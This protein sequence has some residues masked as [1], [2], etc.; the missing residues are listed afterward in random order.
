[1]RKWGGAAPDAGVLEIGPGIGVLTCELA[2]RAGK[3]VA[4]ELDKR[5][6]PVLEETLHDYSNV[7]VINQDVM[8]ADLA[9]I[10]KKEF[11]KMGCVCFAQTSLLHHL[12]GD[13][14]AI[15]REVAHQGHHSYGAKKSG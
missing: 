10:I 6:L 8:K 14:A 13:Y 1:M 2:Q 4:V 9:G 11:G 5:L 15:R 12:A 7:T 3:V